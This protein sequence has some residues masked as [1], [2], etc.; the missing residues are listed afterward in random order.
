M[1]KIT[2]LDG[3]MGRELRNIGAPFSNPL[4]SAQ[5]LIE[6]PEFVALAHRRFIEAGADIITVNSYACV[7]F[8][9][10]ETL[11]SE[12]GAQ[13]TQ[14]A[15]SIAKQEAENATRNVLVAGSLP[16]PFGSYRPD[17]FEPERAFDILNTLVESQHQ[18]V[19]LWL[20]ETVSSIEEAR[21]IAHALEETSLP[22]Y[23]AFSLSDDTA[24]PAMLR[25]GESVTDAIEAIIESNIDG[26]LFNCSI[27]EVI[28]QALEVTNTV[29]SKH[30]KTIS[31]GA[32]ANNFTPISTQHQ[33]NETIQTTRDLS[34]LEYLEFVKQWHKA[35]ATIL[36]GCCGIG[37][38]HI[39]AIAKWSEE[40]N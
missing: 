21:A 1:K 35:E 13:L 37:P 19:D 15:A 3:G 39:A 10:G 22:C 17:L 26:I 27:P 12:K 9:L 23:Y 40:N 20:A 8:H 30:N 6:A 7:P 33:A 31:T 34:P 38:S 5:A 14:L 2:I 24:Q 28:T 25:S 32:F 16:P 18:Y 36:G 29:L 4:W 11:Y